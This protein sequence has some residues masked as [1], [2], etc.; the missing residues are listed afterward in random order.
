MRK[1]KSIPAF[2]FCVL[3][4]MA[5]V[6]GITAVVTE[7]NAGFL[8]TYFKISKLYII[9][10]YSIFPVAFAFADYFLA[11][12]IRKEASKERRAIAGTIL[13]GMVYL[14]QCFY[15]IF[16]NATKK[17]GIYTLVV[18]FL[19]VYIYDTYHTSHKELQGE[20]FA[21]TKNATGEQAILNFANRKICKCHQAI[22]S[23][24]LYKATETMSDNQVCYDVEYIDSSRRN[25]TNLNAVLNTQLIIS[26][27]D[28]DLFQGFW[29]TYKNFLNAESDEA[30]KVYAAAMGSLSNENI[31]KLKD[32]L[33]NH[34]VTTA[35]IKMEDCCI[36]RL[37][38]IYLSCLA[39]IDKENAGD[40]A[41]AACVSLNVCSDKEERDEINKQLFSKFRTGFLG[42]L[43]LKTCP[44]VFYYEQE[45]ND[46]KA[47]RRYVSFLLDHEKAKNS[48]LVLITANVQKDVTTMPSPLLRAIRSIH[49]ECVKIYEKNE[50]KLDD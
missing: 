21:E 14:L 30:Q 34:I 4:L 1:K 41:G 28:Y 13:F 16:S 17:V 50:V 47:N 29:E 8:S 15:D 23:I 44:Y 46:T 18:V 5:V 6:T 20:D 2:I 36:S 45:Q 42:A 48:Y 10:I 33:T 43:L 39:R 40:Y 11:L 7:S 26:K 3:L 12:I 25:A 38:L 24:Q 22:T 35:G 37:V 9:N 49:Q 31:S 19:A 27:E 32:K